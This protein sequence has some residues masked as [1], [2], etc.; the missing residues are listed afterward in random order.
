MSVTEPSAKDRSVSMPPRSAASRDA[1][2]EGSHE[3]MKSSPRPVQRLFLMKRWR[4][5]IATSSFKSLS[6]TTSRVRRSCA[7]AIS[8]RAKATA[9]AKIQ[10]VSATSSASSHPGTN[11]VATGAPRAAN[12]AT[13]VMDQ[14]V[15]V[16]FHLRLKRSFHMAPSRPCRRST[17]ITERRSMTGQL[18]M[19][20]ART[21]GERPGKTMPRSRE[22]SMGGRQTDSKTGGQSTRAAHSTESRCEK[23][24]PM[25]R[26]SSSSAGSGPGS[27]WN[28]TSPSSLISRTH[29]SSTAGSTSSVASSSSPSASNACGAP[30]SPM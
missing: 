30:A 6:R 25:F 26:S 1:R 8:T 12:I 14:Q 10:C 9:F 27:S 3:A 15:Q 20:T 28:H 29:S 18:H 16:V 22:S 19:L 2:K 23:S 7:M 5:A 24:T 4:H 17:T 21:M 13:K 11:P